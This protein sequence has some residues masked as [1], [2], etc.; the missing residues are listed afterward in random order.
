MPKILQHLIKII[1]KDSRVLDLGCGDGL[2]LKELVEKKNIKPLGLEYN[3]DCIEN[4]VKNNVPVLQMDIGTG[5]EIFEDKQ[6]DVAVLHFT[7]QEVSNPLLLYRE[8]MRIS[9]N[10]IIVFSNFAHWKIR[11][12]LLRF[13]KMPITDNLPYRWYE[14]PNIHLMSYVDLLQ[15]CKDQGGKVIH[16]K[17]FGESLIDKCLITS[18]FTNLGASSALV[19]MKS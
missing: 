1:P 16:S 4:C 11:L 8:M 19:H 17:F 14:T 10:C 3:I 2:L 12:N 9:H 5:L 15:L 18:G 7:I 13:G 6:F